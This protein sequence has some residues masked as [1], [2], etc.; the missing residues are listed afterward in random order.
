V[1]WWK[2]GNTLGGWSIRDD[3]IPIIPLRENPPVVNHIQINNL[4]VNNGSI[5]MIQG[6]DVEM[7]VGTPQRVRQRSIP[8]PELRPFFADDVPDQPPPPQQVEEEEEEEQQQHQ[9]Q[10][11][12]LC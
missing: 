10:S 2:K 12:I 1:R 11:L 5:S 7:E 8:P 4:N 6:M 9:N 3:L